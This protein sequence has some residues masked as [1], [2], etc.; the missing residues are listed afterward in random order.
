[1]AKTYVTRDQVGFNFGFDFY[2]SR[3]IF[4]N[5]WLTNIVTDEVVK[6]RHSGAI[7]ETDLAV[8]KFVFKYTFITAEMVR[9][10][11]YPDASVEAIEAKMESLVKGRFLNKFYLSNEER[12]DF[13]D[14]AFP[15]YCM[16]Y[17]G[18]ALLNNYGDVE[19]SFAIEKWTSA[20]VLMSSAR[21]S[22]KLISANFYA[23]LVKNCK[24]NL[25]YLKVSPTYRKQKNPITPAFEF[26][27][28]S[29]GGKKYFIGLT[30]RE[31]SLIP[32]FRDMASKIEDFI[33]S[34]LWA[35]IFHDGGNSHPVVIVI[36]DND[37]VAL[38]AAKIISSATSIKAI[39]YTTDD[40][41]KRKLSERGAFLKFVPAGESEDFPEAHLEEVKASVFS[42]PGES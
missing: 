33:C 42:A 26:C 25:V 30:A 18:K 37:L 17:A 7:T 19:D 31:V 15:I 28:N 6:M 21:I 9:D 5:R 14:D 16:D 29:N 22:S 34:N 13:P 2:D 38:E 39:R 8:I 20:S 11:Y 3:Q 32:H 4:R 40:R 27:L 23:K 1:M 24:E 41:I 12:D 35:K 10:M 36:A